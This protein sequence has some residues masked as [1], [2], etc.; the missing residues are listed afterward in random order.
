MHHMRY[1]ILKK[2]KPPVVKRVQA[3]KGNSCECT[4]AAHVLVFFLVEVLVSKFAQ[5]L[6]FQFDGV[7][8]KIIVKV[9]LNG[10]AFNSFTADCSRQQSPLK[11][12]SIG[13]FSDVALLVS[14]STPN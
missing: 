12:H 6:A 2:V 10:F 5:C 4:S 14:F 9:S 7:I 3:N 13:A 1:R 8:V 11:A